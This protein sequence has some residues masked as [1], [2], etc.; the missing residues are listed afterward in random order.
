ME[1]CL[2][3]AASRIGVARE[4]MPWVETEFDPEFRQYII[5]FSKEQLPRICELLQIYN[6]NKQII[7]FLSRD[8]ADGWLKL[9]RGKES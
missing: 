4:D 2:E 8:E 6:E 5:D 3:S 9:R 1:L 7:I